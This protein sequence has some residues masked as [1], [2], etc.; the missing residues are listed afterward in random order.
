MTL[1]SKTVFC[2]KCGKETTMTQKNRECL[3]CY[4]FD[5][6]HSNVL[7]NGKLVHRGVQSTYD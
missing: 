4:L 3:R 2:A 5:I 1:F 6:E 7:K